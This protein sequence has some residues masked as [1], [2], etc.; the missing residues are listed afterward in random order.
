MKLKDVRIQN[1]RCISDS[2]NFSISDVTCLVGKNESGK[3]AILQALYKLNPIEKDKANYNYLE[4]YPRNELSDYESIKEENPAN[5]LTTHW[6]LEEKDVNVLEEKYG[7]YPLKNKFLEI[8]KGYDNTRYFSIEI[9]SKKLLDFYI[10]QLSQDDKNVMEISKINDIPELIAQLSNIKELSDTQKEVLNSLNKNYPDGK[11]SQSII[12]S[13]DPLIPKFVYFPDYEKMDGKIAINTLNTKIQ[14]NQLFFSEKIF[15]A[16]LDLAGT[17]H[18][19]I[20]NLGTL[21]HLIARLEGISNRITKE[22]FKYWSQNRNLRV[23][24]RFD[25][26]RPQDPAPYNSG[27]IFLTRIE[28]LR[29]GVTVS[30]DDRSSGFIWFFSF[31]VWFSQAQKNYG[32]NLFILLDEPGLSLHAKAQADLLKYINEKLKPYFQIIYSTHSPFMID[33]ENLMNVRTV[34]DLVLGEEVKG[35]KV[36]DKVLSTDSDTLFPLQAALGYEITQ[37]LFVGKHTLLV[38]GPSDLLYLNW[39]SNQLKKSNRTYLNPKWII[40]PSG[41]I[42]KISSFVTLFGGNK[43]HIAVLSDY[44][45]GDKKKV[46]NLRESELLK[47]GHIFTADVFAE[48]D[49]AD[50]EDIIGRT[51]YIALINECYG[52]T[53]KNKLPEKKPTKSPKRVVQEVEDHFRLITDGT[54]MFD[55]FSPSVYLTENTK[56][57]KS[58]MIDLKNALDKFEKLF[59]ELNQLLD[60][61]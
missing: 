44:H 43:L 55:H 40:S 35:T 53:D 52:L 18:Q 33:S 2:N 46:K 26:A 12:N 60:D 14:N 61:E 19:E 21:E 57:I 56:T 23:N 32:D 41:G 28:N 51:N 29:H 3:S 13:I 59:D 4:E 34:E 5:V 24:F 6:E 16:L 42:D 45:E 7:I 30:F 31:L 15:L 11:V 1:Y 10:K 8:S 54:P 38:E 17:S 25:N 47:N 27:Y 9:D 58:K 50:I 36:G 37:T 20:Q 22:I 48:Q 49:E 39:F